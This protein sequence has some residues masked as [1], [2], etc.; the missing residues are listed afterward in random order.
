MKTIFVQIPSYRDTECQWT[1]KDLFE[2]AKKPERINVGICWQY[3]PDTDQDCFQLSVEPARASHV[4][5]SPFHW[6]ESQGVCWA[7]HQAEQLFD[8][9][10]YTLI[11]D[12]HMR[13]APGWDERMI[14]ELGECKSKKPVLSYHPAAYTPPDKLDAKAMPTVL[15]VT[16]FTA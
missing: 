11:I 1:V 6:R 12:S 4:R 8:G 7:R 5:I 2:K 10:D 15:C 14:A 16:P 3:D 13:F 9:E